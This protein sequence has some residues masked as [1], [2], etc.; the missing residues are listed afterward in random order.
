MRIVVETPRWSFRKLKKTETG[1]KNVLTSPVPTPFNY[2]YI[3]GTRG[4]DG[5][6]LD[7]IIL[8]SK[9]QSGTTVN[10][11]VIGRVLFIDDGKRDY[12]YY[13]KTIPWSS[14]IP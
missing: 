10:E 2:G 11:G 7:A 8:G 13:C 5:M 4:E 9:L 1:F 6:P 14:Q 12:K 3:P